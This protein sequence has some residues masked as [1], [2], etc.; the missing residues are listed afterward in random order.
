MQH[1]FTVDLEDWYHGIPVGAET[2]A[3]A[4]R[5]LQV[6]TD[7]LLELLER[8][9]AKATV[10]SLGPTAREYPDLVRR[11]AQA[12]HDVGS[13]GESHDLLYEMTPER[14]REETNRS[15]HAI[16][17]CC[18]RPVRSYRAAY[19]S[20]TEESLWALG[21]LASAGIAY[22][23]SVFPVRNWRY[24][25]PGYSRRPLRI[26]TACGPIWEIPLSTR[27]VLGRNLPATGGAYF[28]IYPYALTR[29]NI[30]ALEREGMPVV[31]YLHP[32]ELDPD[33]PRV[34]FHWK[35]RLTHYFN[36]RSTLPRLERL[37]AEF[38]FTTLAEALPHAVA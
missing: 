9:R 7:R 36:L 38:R 17:D 31:F 6:G 3:L 10:F 37:L 19:F 35:A 15:I 8:H 20:M 33:H 34:R 4:E 28:R 23:S 1:A 5:R 29:A 14:F 18:G 27:R 24:G 12:G 13:H 16:E 11:I 26:A 25:I 22:D 2:K 21:I 32:W 30:R